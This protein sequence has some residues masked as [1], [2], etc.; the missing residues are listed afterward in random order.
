MNEHYSGMENPDTP[1]TRQYAGVP[2][3]PRKPIAPVGIL[4]PS[5][6]EGLDFSRKQCSL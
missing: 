6:N 5:C 2:D 3:M 1:D 4:R